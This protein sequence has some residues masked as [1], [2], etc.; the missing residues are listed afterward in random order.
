M[1]L[2]VVSVVLRISNFHRKQSA[3]HRDPAVP[4]IV[5]VALI[6]RSLQCP[7]SF[8]SETAASFTVLSL[9]QAQLQTYRGGRA[10]GSWRQTSLTF[11][12]GESRSFTVSHKH[13]WASLKGLSGLRH[14]T[15]QLWSPSVLWS[16]DPT[17]PVPALPL[18][19][20]ELHKTSTQPVVIQK[21]SQFES[22]QVWK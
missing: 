2:E 19:H 11:S 9:M 15:V 18:R 14:W 3:L 7:G 17:T 20:K 22:I 1:P 12:L 13:S 8:Q 6:T 10:S 4:S 5:W 21:Q 16:V